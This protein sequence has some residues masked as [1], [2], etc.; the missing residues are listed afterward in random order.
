MPVHDGATQ[1]L[2]NAVLSLSQ[3]QP[4]RRP[5]VDLFQD[6]GCDLHRQPGHRGRR[7][8][9]LKQEGEQDAEAALHV[10]RMRHSSADAK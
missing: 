9:R 7:V 6:L 3:F 10:C 5:V 1:F 8:V 4:K 2:P